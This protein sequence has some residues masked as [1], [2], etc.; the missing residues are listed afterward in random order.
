MDSIVY[1]IYIFVLLW[2]CS[3]N[4]ILIVFFDFDCR[5]FRFRREIK[6]GEDVDVWIKGE[7][8]FK[9]IFG[10]KYLYLYDWLDRKGWEFV[11]LI[12]I[13]FCIDC[14]RKKILYCYC[15]KF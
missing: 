14:F 7:E 11:Y 12:K 13:F 6:K 4:L 3:K 9:I 2:F 1:G 8:N 5:M 15:Y 10:W